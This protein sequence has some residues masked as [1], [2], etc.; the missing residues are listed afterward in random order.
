MHIHDLNEQEE[1][2]LIRLLKAVIRADSQLTHQEGAEMKRVAVAMGPA[3][4]M[5]RIE[6]ARQLTNR[7]SEVKA[8]AEKAKR[9]EARQLIHSMLTEMAERDGMD[10]EASGY[11]SWYN[12]V[13]RKTPSSQHASG[14]FAAAG[15]YTKR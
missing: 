3:R 4:F 6:Q 9:P 2:V 5:E 11:G 14:V 8:A 15:H 10:P 7:L 1:L 12:C 13:L